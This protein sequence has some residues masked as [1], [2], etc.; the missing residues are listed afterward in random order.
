[1]GAGNGTQVLPQ[2]ECPLLATEPS[3]HS[4]AVL[5]GLLEPT[6]TI[7]EREWRPGVTSLSP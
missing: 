5:Y 4:P 6:T 2:E 3:L 7:K 1:M